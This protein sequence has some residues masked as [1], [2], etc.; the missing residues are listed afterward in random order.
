MIKR[1]CD[2][3]SQ[4][5]RLS[6]KP[7]RVFSTQ[8]KNKFNRFLRRRV[9][10]RKHISRSEVSNCTPPA[11]NRGMERSAIPFVE[12]G[13]TFFD[14]L[15]RGYAPALPFYG[16]KYG[17][18]FLLCP[19]ADVFVAQGVDDGEDGHAQEHAR[20]APEPAAGPD[21]AAAGLWGVSGSG[22]IPHPPGRAPLCCAFRQ[23]SLPSPAGR[24]RSAP[25]RLFPVLKS[26]L[27]C[28]RPPVA[29]AAGV[30]Y[31][32]DNR[33]TTSGRPA[34]RARAPIGAIIS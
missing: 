7:R 2:Q 29:P 9:R 21:P 16:L 24:R 28:N 10:R 12:E 4:R 19:A 30:C 34:R 26:S 32:Y 3:K 20:D 11:Y 18:L 33:T 23:S 22:G 8:R 15:S 14:K 6:K 25:G 1:R 13:L 27:F 17:S 5:L 31:N